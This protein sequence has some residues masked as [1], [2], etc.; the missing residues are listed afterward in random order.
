MGVSEN[1]TNQ[2]IT[3]VDVHDVLDEER[4]ENEQARGMPKW[5]VHTLCDSKLDAPMS[6]RTRS[7]RL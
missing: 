3:D 1:V 7:D 5:L 2:H 4:A 6:S